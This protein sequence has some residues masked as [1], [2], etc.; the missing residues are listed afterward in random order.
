MKKIVTFYLL[1][2]YLSCF[3]QKNTPIIIEW[4][5]KS[6]LNFSDVKIKTPVFKGDTY[7]Y[8]F[9]KNVIYYTKKELVTSYVD[10]SSLQI[11]NVVY[12]N[13]LEQDLGQINGAELPSS[14]KAT[15]LKLNESASQILKLLQ[16]N[17][18]V[19]LIV[20]GYCSPLA[21]TS[22]NKI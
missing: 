11:S 6:E 18:V 17:K 4:S 15:I 22:Y 12:Q 13:I 8:D 14:L 1:F 7:V 5:D 19:K 2:F 9:E 16:H 3:S 20:K 21:S 10:E